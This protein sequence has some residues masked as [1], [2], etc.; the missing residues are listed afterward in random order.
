MLEGE[1][2]GHTK[3]RELQLLRQGQTYLSEQWDRYHYSVGVPQM[4][5][6]TT[7]RWLDDEK[8]MR[9]LLVISLALSAILLTS[10]AA[11]VAETLHYET[12]YVGDMPCVVVSRSGQ[13]TGDGVAISCD[14]ESCGD[15][16]RQVIRNNW[17]E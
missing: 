7:T 15:A 16:C 8:Q 6:G 5:G 3:M 12:V 14:W 4:R 2:E 13:A 1:N 11:D 9:T 10:C 17:P